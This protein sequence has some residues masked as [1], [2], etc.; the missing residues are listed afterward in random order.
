[1]ERQKNAGFTDGTP[2]IKLNPNYKYINA[3]S[4]LEDE[5]SIFNYYKKLIVLRRNHEIIV[6]GDYNLILE[7]NKDIYAYTRKLKDETL[8]VICNFCENLTKFSLP[9]NIKYLHGELLI[10]NY[11]VEAKGIDEIVLR[12]YEARVYLLK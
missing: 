1:M 8:L 6:Y 2:W 12:P 3:Q 11:I 5:Y 10:S 7:D 4:Q 9:N